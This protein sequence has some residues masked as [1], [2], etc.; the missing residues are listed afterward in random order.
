M[1]ESKNKNSKNN[2]AV[3]EEI[4][5]LNEER[6]EKIKKPSTPK[7]DK[8]KKDAADKPAKRVFV[9]AEGS[10]PAGKRKFKTHSEKKKHQLDSGKK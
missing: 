7:T 4:D 1:N 6:V 5:N 10:K 3:L 8:P 9:K 2:T